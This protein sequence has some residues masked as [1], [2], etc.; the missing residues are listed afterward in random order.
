M[1]EQA[2]TGEHSAASLNP[3]IVRTF[4]IADVRGYTTFTNKQGVPAAARLADRFAVL[5]KVVVGQHG[6]EVIE[7][8]GDESLSVFESPRSALLAAVALQARFQEELANDP[9]LPLRVGMGIDV[10]DVVPFQGGYRGKGTVSEEQARQT[11]NSAETAAI[12]ELV[13]SVIE[14]VPEYI[15]LNVPAENTR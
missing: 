11:E 13:R 2:I 5:S 6:G 3:S 15:D 10:G 12:V 9:T 8:R 7:L 4:L 14:G 1:S